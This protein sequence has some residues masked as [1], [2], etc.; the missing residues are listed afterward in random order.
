MYLHIGYQ[1]KKKGTCQETTEEVFCTN[2]L[3]EY[4]R[5]YNESEY[6]AKKL[7]DW[8]EQLEVITTYMSQKDHGRTDI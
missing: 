1:T 4:I 2:G 8:L 6:T 3:P 7:R 5:S